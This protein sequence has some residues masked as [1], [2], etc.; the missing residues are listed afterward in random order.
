MPTIPTTFV[1]TLDLPSLAA[2]LQP[3]LTGSPVATGGGTTPPVVTL[4]A[5]IPRLDYMIYQNGAGA[6]LQD[7]SWAARSIDYHDTSGQP[8]GGKADLA[9]TLDGPNGGYQP[10]FVPNGSTTFLD[11]TPFNYLLISIKPTTDGANYWVGFAGNKDTADGN[12]IEIAGPGMTKYGPVPVK[13]QWADYKIPLADFKMTNAK[14][15]FKVGI[16]AGN[17]PGGTTTFFD[18]LGFTKT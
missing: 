12:Q 5:G 15:V 4:P 6:L 18:S 3:F 10:L 17:F 7:D 2:A 9:F 16:A 8:Q 11:L 1:L 14:A 13:G